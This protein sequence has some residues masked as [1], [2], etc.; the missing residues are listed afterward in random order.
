MA[1][2]VIDDPYFE[3]TIAQLMNINEYR[4]KNTLVDRRLTAVAC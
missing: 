4:Y 3:L 1:D 2:R